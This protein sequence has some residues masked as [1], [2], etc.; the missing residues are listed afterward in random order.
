MVTGFA[1]LD[2]RFG[3]RVASQGNR[4]PAQLQR[5]LWSAGCIDQRP[6]DCADIVL[7]L[8]CCDLRGGI[9]SVA[10]A[11]AHAALS[12]R[13]IGLKIKTDEADAQ[14]ARGIADRGPLCLSSKDRVDHDGMTVRKDA[15]GL[16][17][18]HVVDL[19]G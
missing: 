10:S 4:G 15:N 18:E 9:G 17:S 3:P 5:L 19:L 11:A 7:F 14:I 2:R 12:G 13:K 6:V 8:K 1:S 16:L